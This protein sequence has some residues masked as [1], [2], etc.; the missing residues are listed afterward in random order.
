[1]KLVSFEGGFGRVEDGTIIP[2]GGDI[3]EYLET[4]DHHDGDAMSLDSVRLMAPIPKPGKILP[5]GPSYV[6]HAREAG[7][8]LPQS[9]D[10]LILMAKF[11]NSVT[12][13]A[14][15]IE[16]PKA[17]SQ[18]DYE[19][20]LA[21]V[22]GRRGREIPLEDVHEYVAGY[23]CVND[24]S[25]R[26][27]QFRLGSGW[28][29]AKAIDTFLPCGPWLVTPDEVGDVHNL[30]IRCYLNDEVMQDSN[31]SEL[32]FSVEEMIHSISKTVTLEPGDVI[33]TGTPP[34][35]GYGRKPQRFLRDGD[36]VRVEIDKLGEL[37]N[38]VVN[39]G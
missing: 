9:A 29:R 39:R 1:M 11:H 24:V 20:E 32:L 26:D 33:P 14:D 31:T 18:N 25:E 37:R 22:I 7:Q 15:D 19:A 3:I 28:T 23:M 16:L 6:A 5:M 17:T 13:P 27:L 8:P 38:R 12:G 36:V 21:V 10:E 30:Q 35:V 2:M 34:G 4:G